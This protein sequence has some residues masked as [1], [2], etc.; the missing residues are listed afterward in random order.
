MIHRQQAI[1]I[2]WIYLG[3]EGKIQ[4]AVGQLLPQGGDGQLA[5]AGR[6]GQGGI[7]LDGLGGTRHPFGGGVVDVGWVHEEWR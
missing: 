3:P 4:A 7:E 5:I 2:A 1:G 6:G